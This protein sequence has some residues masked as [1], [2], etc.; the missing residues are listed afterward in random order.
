[1]DFTR[2]L[3]HDMVIEDGGKL[4]KQTPGLEE[5]RPV[6]KTGQLRQIKILKCTTPN[7]LGAGWLIGRPINHWLSC[8]R[9]RHGHQGC[10]LTISMAAAHVFVLNS[11][12][13]EIGISRFRH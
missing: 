11:Q 5:R 12:L 3:T 1:M 4:A 2:L 8:A 13:F 6:N 10:D 9:I 7:K